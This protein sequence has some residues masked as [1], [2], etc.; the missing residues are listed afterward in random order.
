MMKREPSSALRAPS[1][2]C[3]SKQ[4][5]ANNLA[6]FSRAFFGMGEGADRRMRALPPE[7]QS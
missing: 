6:A 7:K 3:K 2:I 4:A 1:P 5:K